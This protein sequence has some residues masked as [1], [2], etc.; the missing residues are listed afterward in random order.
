MRS[1]ANKVSVKS[2]TISLDGV[3]RLYYQ[4]NRQ[5]MHRTHTYA[6]SLSFC[7]REALNLEVVRANG[8]AQ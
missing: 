6:S 2:Q 7:H 5:A 4:S 8:G 1:L 3:N